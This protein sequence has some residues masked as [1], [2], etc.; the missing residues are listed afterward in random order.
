MSMNY[1]KGSCCFLEQE[2]YPHCLVLVGAWNRFQ[3]DVHMQKS[4][5][6]YQT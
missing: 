2:T 3:L 6:H 1:I 4:L 5:F